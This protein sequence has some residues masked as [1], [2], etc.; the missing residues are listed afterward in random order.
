MLG[1]RRGVGVLRLRFEQCALK[2]ERHGSRRFV[3]RGEAGVVDCDCD[4]GCDGHGDVCPC[5][6][7]DPLC[8]GDDCSS[9]AGRRREARD[10]RNGRGKPVRE[11]CVRRD[12]PLRGVTETSAYSRSP[13]EGI[14]RGP[15]AA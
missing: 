2:H 15:D 11:R 8:D 5:D 12:A 10:R 1:A 7:P 4:T 14:A 9:R 3:P 13:A 6:L